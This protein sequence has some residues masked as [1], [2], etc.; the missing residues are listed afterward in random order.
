MYI[1][2][3]VMFLGIFSGLALRKYLAKIPIQGIVFAAV[4]ALL[5]LLGAQIGANERLFSD[6]PRLGGI[7]LLFACFCM[8]GS[9]A[10]VWLCSRLMR[11]KRLSENDGK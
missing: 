11:K 7:A 5:F 1:A 4:L 10:A 3:A 6:L 8:S 9:I 2:L